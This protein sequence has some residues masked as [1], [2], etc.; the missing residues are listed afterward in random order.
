MLLKDRRRARRAEVR[1]VVKLMSSENPYRD[2]T[3]QI[4]FCNPMAGRTL[5]H[6]GSFRRPSTIKS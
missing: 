2:R 6:G 1:E 4:L 3:T 5:I